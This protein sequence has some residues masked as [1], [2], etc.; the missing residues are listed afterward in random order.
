VAAEVPLVSVVTPVY[1][2]G[3]YLAECMQS[4]LDQT[5]ERWEYVVCDNQSTDDSLA[6]AREFEARDKRIRVVAPPDFVGAIQNFNRAIREISP[7]SVYT[8]VVCAD[9][10]LFPEC[11]ARMVA[12]AEKHPSVGLVSAYC[13]WGD[14]VA[15]KLL[16]ERIEIM[17]GEEICRLQLGG[18][19]EVFGSPTSTLVRSDL[20]RAR[21]PFY[22][23][24]FFHADTEVCFHLL[25]EADFGF[26]H[27]VLTF[28]RLHPEAI[29]S[30]TDRVGSWTPE[31][32][33][34][35][36]TY[37][38]KCLP[39]D[40]YERTLRKQLRSYGSMLARKAVRL[41]FVSDPGMRAYHAEALRR[42]AVALASDDSP[43]RTERGA[44]AAARL[45][46][47]VLGARGDFPDG[48]DARWIGSSGGSGT[49][50]N[51]SRFDRRH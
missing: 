28:T 47:R 43:T 5:Y 31:R 19:E 37:G 11:L 39:R 24:A 30:F 32:L 20:V 1:N 34:M 21:D 18:A 41:R 49:T 8:K 38:P 4:V 17:P 35:L 13:R 12:L 33:E 23:E 42:L 25:Q 7:E 36:L 22:R 2:G 26:V 10:C 44:G 14:K 6:L 9:D 3:K 46:A 40:E 51:G 29:S 45:G 50:P 48:G 15:H 27:E 16:P